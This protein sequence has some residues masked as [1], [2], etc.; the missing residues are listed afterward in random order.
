MRPPRLV[1]KK[2]KKNG[3][4]Y[5]PR[6]KGKFEISQYLGFEKSALMD[7]KNTNKT[8]E[9]GSV[10]ILKI[11][12]LHFSSSILDPRK[13]A[14]EFSSFD[15]WG[16]RRTRR[17]ETLHTFK[18]KYTQVLLNIGMM[19]S[20][21]QLILLFFIQNGVARFDSFLLKKWLDVL[22]RTQDLCPPG[23]EPYLLPY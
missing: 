20:N 22:W 5:V 7:G 16:G 2:R 3:I 11:S 19:I 21:Q 10:R 13:G 15:F 14:V 9:S 6:G 18:K 17:I 23:P 1:P 4:I 12:T 8:E